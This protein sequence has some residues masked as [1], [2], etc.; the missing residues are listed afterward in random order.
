MLTKLESL[1]VLRKFF[2]KK[3]VADI[4]ELLALLK[5]TSRMSGFRRLKELNYLSSY[6][7]AGSYYTLAHIPHFDSVGLWH[8][9]GIGFSKYGNLKTT[10]IQ[11][12]SQSNTGMTHQELEVQ[13]GVRVY[14]T[15]LDLVRSHQIKRDQVEGTY[16]YISSDSKRA[17]EQLVHRQE[18]RTSRKKTKPLP[19]WVVVEILAEAIRGSPIHVDSQKIANQLVTRGMVVTAEQVDH[20]FEQYHLKKNG[21]RSHSSVKK[22]D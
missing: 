1:K 6:S 2:R 3:P 20:V 15:L 18:F 10:L 13:L 21:L 16:L 12:I 8:Y 11:L 22:S 7:H 17:N 5:T 4:T 9:E 19:V 14:N